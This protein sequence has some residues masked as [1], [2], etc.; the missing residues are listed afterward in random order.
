MIQLKCDL[1]EKVWE[2]DPD[3]SPPRDWGWDGKLTIILPDGWTLSTHSYF[4]KVSTLYNEE[5]REYNLA[6]PDCQADP[7]AEPKEVDD[8][9]QYKPEIP[10]DYF[11]PKPGDILGYE[12]PF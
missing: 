1:C 11:E 3:Q 9:T 4:T 6:C 10:P 5:R 12:Y 7:K 2:D 8:L